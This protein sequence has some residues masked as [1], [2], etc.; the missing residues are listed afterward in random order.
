[1]TAKPRRA[2]PPQGEAALTPAT[3]A[4]TLHAAVLETLGVEFRH[5]FEELAT[6]WF[7]AALGN[8]YARGYRHGNDDGLKDG[9]AEA[10]R[11][12]EGGA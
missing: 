8:A 3:W 10:Q 2:R 5:S 9:K 7:A 4:I 11:A 6:K 1:M 12:P